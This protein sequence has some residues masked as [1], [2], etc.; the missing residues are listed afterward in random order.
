MSSDTWA[1][2]HNPRKRDQVSYCDQS[3]SAWHQRCEDIILWAQCTESQ[4]EHP[5]DFN[6]WPANRFEALPSID[7][8]SILTPVRTL[9]E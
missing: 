3:P 9:S 4:A 7:S 2:E 1:T 5:A 6:L 8:H